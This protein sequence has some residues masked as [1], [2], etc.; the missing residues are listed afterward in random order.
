MNFKKILITFGKNFLAFILG[1][2]IGIIL[3]FIY[4]FAIWLPINGPEIGLAIIALILPVLI[5]FGGLGFV[6]GG[7]LGIIIYQIIKYLRKR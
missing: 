2:I 4:T 7:I 6:I 1:G 3:T 5:L